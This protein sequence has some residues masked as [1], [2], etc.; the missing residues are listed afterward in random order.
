MSSANT[1]VY[2]QL[3][4]A[5]ADYLSY[6]EK[7]CKENDLDYLIEVQVE[8]KD[9]DNPNRWVRYGDED[10]SNWARSWC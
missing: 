3:K 10:S 8:P 5:Y 9:E 4:S 1:K 7:I 6:V 2:E